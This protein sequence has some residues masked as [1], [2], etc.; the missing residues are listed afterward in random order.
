MSVSLSYLSSLV[1]RAGKRERAAPLAARSVDSCGAGRMGEAGLMADYDRKPAR[2]DSAP[3]TA[4]Q[5][6]ANPATLA[7]IDSAIERGL[8]FL[9]RSQRDDG[10]FPNRFWEGP[11]D[12]VWVGNAFPA[13]LI[14]HSLSFVPGSQPVRDRALDFLE[15]EMGPHGLWKHWSKRNSNHGWFPP[16]VDDTACASAALAAAGRPVPDNRRLLLAN[17]DRRGLFY[18]WIAWRPSLAALAQLRATLPQLRHVRPLF[19]LFTRT[20]A[21]IHDVD[22]AVNANM[23]FYLG[24][25]AETEPVAAYLLDLIGRHAE[26]ECDTWYPS[27][28]AIWYFSARALSGCDEA[29][30]L[31]LGRLAATKPGNALERAFAACASLYCGRAPSEELVASILAGQQDD[32]GWPADTIYIG[33]HCRWGSEQ[34]TAAFSLEALAR[35]RAGIGA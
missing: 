7:A 8:A 16:D 4:P 25:T 12:P 26:R 17:R 1:N 23:L 34:L 15:R 35:I 11:A 28:F 32:G 27:P 21:S 9:E 18:T 20:A 6:G 13:A 30:A 3:G 29:G 24:R 2:I 22:G 31:I 33:G 19:T 14:A 10:E 5:A